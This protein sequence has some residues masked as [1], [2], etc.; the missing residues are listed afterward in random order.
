MC[1]KPR[2]NAHEVPQKEGNHYQ[3]KKE[4]EG[5][6]T[7]TSIYVDISRKPTTLETQPKIIQETHS[8]IF[9]C[10]LHAHFMNAGNPG[11][12]E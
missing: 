5:K 6:K 10:M 3:Q 4:E 8:R 7:T 2:R 1:W 12:V 9:T 11:G